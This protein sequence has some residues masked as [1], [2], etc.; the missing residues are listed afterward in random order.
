MYL[1]VVGNIGCGKSSL[2]QKLAQRYELTPVY[3]PVDENPYLPDFYRDLEHGHKS[4][5]A[6]HSQV[7]F[8]AKR[9]EQHLRDINTGLRVIQDRTVFEDAFIFAQNLALEGHLTQRDWNTYLS[10][11]AGIAPALRTPDLAVYIRCSLATLRQ[12]I[13]LRG[14]TYEKTIPDDYLLQLNTLY[15][16]WVAQYS[17]SPVIVV[18]GDSIDFIAETSG[19]SWICQQ[20]EQAG[21]NEPL[22]V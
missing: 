18:P 16:S 1:A 15:E 5:F 20:L 12:R 6:F 21:L 9:L 4:Q 3:E 13:G 2:T 14:R 8:L 10:L 19:F 11:Y 7:F 17:L 22:L